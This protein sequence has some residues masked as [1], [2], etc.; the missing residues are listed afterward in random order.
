MTKQL[1]FA[2]MQKLKGMLHKI[3]FSSKG[4]EKSSVQLKGHTGEGNFINTIH[5]INYGNMN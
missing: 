4:I 1:G 2:G 3:N 5:K